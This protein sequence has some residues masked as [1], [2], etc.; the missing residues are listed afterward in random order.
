MT[1]S[2]LY[3][4]RVVHTR[5]RP[6]RHR[7]SYACY[8]MLL[9]LDELHDLDRRLRWFSLNRWNVFSLR[10]TDHGSGS[11]IPIR[12]QAERALREA[13]ID[14]AGGRILL[15]A[16]PRILGY[17][18][19]PL[20]IYFC[21][22]RDGT[23][24][25]LIYEVHNTF[26]QRHSYLI[27]SKSEE[28]PEL[29]QR[30][31][32]RFYVSPFLDM[33]LAYDFR[34]MLPAERVRVGITASDSSGALLAASLSG[35]HAPLTDASLMRVFATHPLLTLKVVAAIHWEAVRLWWKGVRLVPRPPPP[36][37]PVTALLD[38]DPARRIS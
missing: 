29:L 32:K 19:N 31:A 12:D 7:L 11:D 33:D 20:S 13:G 21:H 6:R 38:H 35:E 3:I 34:V 1:R 22:R 10:N 27:A 5:S 26:R 14:I 37:T 36:E 4:G 25:A 8:W 15:L 2:A 30:C 24:A 28:G 23:L 18:F 16:M 9:D 17:G